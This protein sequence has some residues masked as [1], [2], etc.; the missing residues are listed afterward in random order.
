VP[1]SIGSSA[2]CGDGIGARAQAGP[3]GTGHVPGLPPAVVVF[4]A[5]FRA[6]EWPITAVGYVA[7]ARR[8]RRLDLV[9]LVGTS[10]VAGC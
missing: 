7:R 1:A 4:V 2:A 9:V 5:L 6:D 10:E 8:H 3:A